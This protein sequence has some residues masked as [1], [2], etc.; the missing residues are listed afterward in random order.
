MKAQAVA[1]ETV[2]VV[3]LLMQA[4]RAMTLPFWVAM[5]WLQALCFSL[6]EWMVLEEA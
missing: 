6:G 4:C 1:E 5:S 3:S 2:G